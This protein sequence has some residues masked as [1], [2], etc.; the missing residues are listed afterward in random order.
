MT[1][2]KCMFFDNIVEYENVKMSTK[3]FIKLI[4]QTES[5]FVKYKILFAIVSFLPII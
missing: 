1:L 3:K 4:S 5:V 2:T